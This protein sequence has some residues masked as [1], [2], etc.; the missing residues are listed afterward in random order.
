MMKVVSLLLLLVGLFACGCAS[1]SADGRQNLGRQQRVF[2]E[3]RLNDNLGIARTFAAELRALGYQATHG[4][5][6]M[7]AEDTQLI[8]TYDA[9]EAWDGRQYL[10]ELNVAV[11]PMRDYNRVIASGRY[12]RPGITNKPAAQMVRDTVRKLFPEYRN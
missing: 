2:V 11:R 4:P 8:V 5:L 6:T 1:L 3:E 12:F 7:A 9:R 10:I